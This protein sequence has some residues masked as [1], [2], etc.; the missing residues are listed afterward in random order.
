[1]IVLDKRDMEAGVVSVRKRGEGDPGA[2]ALE[3]LV[4]CCDL[5]RPRLTFDAPRSE[6][7]LRAQ[8]AEAGAAVVGGV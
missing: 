4:L 1:M 8:V 3:A 7:V 6:R 2:M 5:V